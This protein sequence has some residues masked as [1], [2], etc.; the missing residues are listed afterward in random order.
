MPFVLHLIFIRSHEFRDRLTTV[1]LG[2][3]V[4]IWSH[5][6]PRLPTRWNESSEDLR[7]GRPR[8]DRWDI[9][10]LARIKLLILIH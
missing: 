2:L 9:V 8:F 4:K 5:T 3:D 10:D 6:Q 1:K 7:L